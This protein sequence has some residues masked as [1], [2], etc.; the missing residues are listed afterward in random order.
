MVTDSGLGARVFAASRVVRLGVDDI[1]SASERILTLFLVIA[2]VDIV[3]VS[4][5]LLNMFCAPAFDA[6]TE[7][8]LVIVV[9]IVRI[10]DANLVAVET[11]VIVD[12][13]AL[14]AP[15]TLDKVEVEIVMVSMAS[16]LILADNFTGVDEMTI[17]SE[18][19]LVL[20]AS[21]FMEAVAIVT[22]SV[23]LLLIALA[24]RILATASLIVIV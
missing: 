3:M 16:D 20:A 21:L 19:D 15:L 2:A 17:V 11:I 9:V 5:R 23:R 12:V 10:L 22:V 7:S 24:P 8:A 6:V 14:T 18:R 4:V 13:R 1:V